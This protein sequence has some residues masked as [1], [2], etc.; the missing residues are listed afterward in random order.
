VPPPLLGELSD[1]TVFSLDTFFFALM[2][3]CVRA[4]RIPLQSLFS[5]LPSLPLLLDRALSRAR[6]L[7]G[8]DG[9][10]LSLPPTGEEWKATGK[11]YKLGAREWQSSVHVL[12]R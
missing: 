5:L 7:S 10:W 11:F 9:I 8:T 4:C 12:G 2:E 3:V 1:R 6:A